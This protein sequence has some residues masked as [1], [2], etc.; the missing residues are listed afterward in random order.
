MVVSLRRLAT[1]ESTE[2]CFTVG[3]PKGKGSCKLQQARGALM[4]DLLLVLLL[5]SAFTLQYKYS[6]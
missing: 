6:D 4:Y 3:R 2:S 5:L 1:W